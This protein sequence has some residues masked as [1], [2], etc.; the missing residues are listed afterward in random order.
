MERSEQAWEEDVARSVFHYANVLA[1]R[2]VRRRAPRWD[3]IFEVRTETGI[4]CFAVPEQ[5]RLYGSQK[6]ILA[7]IDAC[8]RVATRG[9]MNA[10]L[11]YLY[12]STEADKIVEY[13]R[14]PTYSRASDTLGIVDA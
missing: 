6:T 7:M 4:A 10:S 12:D 5:T 3:T 8:W 9:N 11:E 14:E 2:S 1:V 13:L